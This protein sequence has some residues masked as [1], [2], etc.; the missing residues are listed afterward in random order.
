MEKMKK[1]IIILIIAALVLIAAGSYVAVRIINR[2]TDIIGVT[3]LEKKNT[4]IMNANA[5]SDYGAGSGK[6][7][8]GEGER[9]HVEYALKAGGFDLAFCQGSN[10]LEVIRSS[11]LQNLSDTG[12]VFGRSGV[13]GSGSLD[14][15]A[16]PG[17]YTVYF[18]RNGAAGT[19]KVTAKAP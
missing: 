15:E 12:E 10:G 2:G 9:I 5:D 11:D 4:V 3:T 1:K 16:A 7:T 17:E 13:S 6:L 18:N 14:F 19:A 8:V